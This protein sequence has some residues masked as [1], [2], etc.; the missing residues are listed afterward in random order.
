MLFGESFAAFC[1]WAGVP[2][3]EMSGVPLRNAA[4]EG[5]SLIGVPTGGPDSV[6][7][8]EYRCSCAV[9]GSIETSISTSGLPENE[10][11]P[12]PKGGVP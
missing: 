8:G 3:R 12:A 5:A 4:A 2:F 7:F 10:C 6:A 11:P 9:D 1:K